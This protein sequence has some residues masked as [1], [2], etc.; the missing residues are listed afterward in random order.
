MQMFYRC[1]IESVLTF[2]FLS[3]YGSLNVKNKNVLERVV[4]VCGKVYGLNQ[5]SLN[6]LY[7][8]CALKKG[9]MIVNECKHIL[10]EKFNLLPSGRRYRVPKTRTLRLKNSFIPRAITICNSSS[11][12]LYQ[13]FV[14]NL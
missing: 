3:W 1:F 2:Y 10:S 13:L 9:R 7:E 6:V 12:T 5:N 11:R 4:K 14:R 8:S